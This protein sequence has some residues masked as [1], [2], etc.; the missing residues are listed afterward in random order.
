MNDPS[1]QTL[2]GL[3]PQRV[4]DAYVRAE[5]AAFPLTSEV[6]FR[7]AMTELDPL[8]DGGGTAPTRELWRDCEKA[9]SEHASGWSLD[10]LV[11][12]RD[13]FWFGWPRAL[14]ARQR[15]RRPRPVTMHRYLRHLAE[16]HLEARPGVTHVV[17]NTELRSLDAVT[18]YRWLTF[19]LPDDLLLVGTGV[20]PP[21]TRVDIEPPLL[22]RRLLDQG[23][24]EIH[25]HAGA[26][27]DFPLL[28]VSVL[29]MLATAAIDPAKLAGPGQPLGGGET[30]LRWLLA[31]AVTRCLLAELLASGTTDT[32]ARFV[33]SRGEALRPSCH[34]TLQRAL[35]AVEAGSDRRLPG[36]LDLRDLYQDMYRDMHP[37]ESRTQLEDAPRTLDEVWR[38]CDPIAARLA[39]SAPGAGERWLMQRGLARIEA[40]GEDAAQEQL[41]FDTLF[42]Q[43]VRL[44]CLLY[45]SIVQ[46]PMTAG[47]QWFVRFADRAAAYRGALRAIYPE[48]SYTVAGG[49]QPIGSLE[50]RIGPDSSPFAMADDLRNLTR[51]WEH[52]LRGLGSPAAGREPEF[53][54]LLHFRKRRYDDARWARGAPP[55]LGAGTHGE[56]HPHKVI[57]LGG[58]YS[59]FFVMESTEAQAIVDLIDAVPSALRLVR[60]LDVASDELSVPTWVVVPLFRYVYNRSALAAARRPSA[61]L[62]PLRLTAHVGEDF[63]HL[64]EG[65]RR[66]YECIQYLL[67]RSGGRLGHATALGVDPRLWAESVGSLMMPAEDRLWDL[68]FEWRVYAHH[69]VPVELGAAA[70][71]QRALRV[72]SDIRELSEWVFRRPYAPNELAEAHHVLHQLWCPPVAASE[73][74]ELG[75]MPFARAAEGGLGASTLRQEGPRAPRRLPRRRGALP[76][77]AAARRH[78]ARG[79]GDQRAPGGSGRLAAVRG[80]ARHRGGG[81]PVQQPPHREPARPAQP[82]PAA[83]VPTGA[84]GRRAAAGADRGRVRRP[85][86]L[87][88][89]PAA[90]VLAALRGRQGRRLSGAGGPR[91][92]GH[93][94]A[95]E[96]RC[97]LHRALETERPACGRHAPRRAGRV[98]AATA[99]E[100]RQEDGMT[101]TVQSRGQ[102]EPYP[103]SVALTRRK[104]RNLS[105]TQL[106]WAK[107]ERTAARVALVRGLSRSDD[108]ADLTVLAQC[109]ERLRLARDRLDRPFRQ[110]WAF[111]ELIH[112]VDELLMLVTPEEML[113][114]EATDVLAKF[115]RKIRDPAVRKAWLGTDGASG[116]LPAVIQR[117]TQ[118]APFVGRPLHVLGP[119][120][121]HLLRGALNLVNEQGD[122]SFWRLA[123]NVA[124][125]TLSALLLLVLAAVAFLRPF[126]GPRP[127][128]L[129]IL[130]L[131]AAG[132]ILANLLA[133]EPFIV[134]IGPTS[135]YYVHGLFVRP[136]LGAFAAGLVCLLGQSG[137]AFVVET[138]PPGPSPVVGHSGPVF[139]LSIL[140]VAAGFAAERMLRPM[141]DKVLRA[142]SAQSEK[143][144]T[145]VPSERP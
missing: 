64:M 49:G 57:R 139:V 24:T 115:E 104:H 19:A 144:A 97:S 85:G 32:V 7:G 128:R 96:R 66:T 63:R 6:A 125:Q 132:A 9:L 117:L 55:A 43:V 113:A 141:M 101:V 58:R 35:G 118:P 112:R 111:W 138:P 105:A 121:R 126:P 79:V 87:Q 37:R 140:A 23:V 110:T 130:M 54:V 119:S 31:A 34:R 92:A 27:M 122:T 48:I 3:V 42:W 2:G 52:V 124:V 4:P 88:H 76:L 108:P 20:D 12:L 36:L 69:R 136:V 106:L 38:R 44:R 15:A 11:A 22:V 17:E 84:R 50:V 16:V 26:G 1:S 13:F 75:L 51:S 71:S 10:R 134:S 77:R 29:A 133:T 25:H 116:P 65:L 74:T 21:P 86:H 143:V 56:P 45:R 145:S 5:V 18:H 123:T 82:S 47:L 61:R 28:W 30:L 78:H 46:R 90:R 137:V 95:D 129:D 14:A 93:D 142:L 80:L 33:A 91:V 68:V 83:A 102:G 72:E 114:A 109:E 120:D 40:A 67:H 70:P 98:P 89:P 53:G 62:S 127:D 60:G 8:L 99:E 73:I 41:R 135:R 103:A 39:L 107:L 81:E 59:D 100:R 131:G 94:P